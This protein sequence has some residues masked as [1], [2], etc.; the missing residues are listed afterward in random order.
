MEYNK[1]MQEQIDAGVLEPVSKDAP[2]VGAC[3]YLPH[4]CVLRDDHDTTKLRVVYDGSSRVVGPSLN[5]SLHQGPCLIPELVRI[6]LRLRCRKYAVIGDLEKAFLQIEVAE[7][8]RNYLRTLWIKNFEPHCSLK[9]RENLELMVLRFTRCVFGVTSSPFHL[10]ATIIRHTAKYVDRY[11]LVVD[12]IR[13]SMYVDDLVS[14]ADTEAEA[15][16]L[17]VTAK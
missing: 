1:V 9:G 14:G 11:K 13:R 4:H 15:Y 2:G 16:S 17:F 3:Y 5:Q 6:L 12:E 8:D 10:L 7:A